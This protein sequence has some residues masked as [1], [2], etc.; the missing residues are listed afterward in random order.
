MHH[1]H[2]TWMALAVLA[3]LSACAP[4][5]Q[6][7]PLAHAIDATSLHLSQGMLP[8]TQANFWHQL[9]DPVLNQLLAQTLSDAPDL[10]AT[11]ARIDGAA[12]QYGLARSQ[13]GPQIA[14]D[15]TYNRQ[16]FSEYGM[17]AGLF[18]GQYMNSFDLSLKG[19]WEFDFWGKHRAQMA[20]AIGQKNA[21][22]YELE[23]TRLMLAQA[24]LTQ[25]VQW[26]SL[27]RK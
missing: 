2:K 11:R 6:Q 16:R 5:G 20:A 24:V 3:L 1:T 13:T 9:N 8:H 10:A 27:L 21:L 18:G 25:Y 12:A 4:M 26:L 19:A 7:K 22:E 14:A 15:A 23:Q 17:Y